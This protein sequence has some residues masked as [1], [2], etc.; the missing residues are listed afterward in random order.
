MFYDKGLRFQCQMC[1]YCCSSEPG[2][3]YLSDKEINEEAEKL[4]LF[5][6][7]DPSNL[8]VSTIG[9]AVA[10]SSGGPRTFKYGSTKDYIIN[11]EASVLHVLLQGRGQYPYP[12]EIIREFLRAYR[13]I[14]RIK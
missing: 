12:A 8:A 4:N 14:Y 1:R 11:L 10:L 6:P 7:P 5:F 2:F 9:G 13:R 3:V